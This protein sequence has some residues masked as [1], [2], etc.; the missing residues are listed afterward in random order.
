MLKNICIFQLHNKIS[1]SRSEYF[2]RNSSLEISSR[3]P[4]SIPPTSL[5][6]RK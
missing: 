2:L 1:Y 4:V 3:R 5:I 6:I